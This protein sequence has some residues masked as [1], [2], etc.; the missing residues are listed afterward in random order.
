MDNQTVQQ[1]VKL[2]SNVGGRPKAID[3]NVVNKLV[4]AFQRGQ[5]DTKACE[6]ARISR[7]TFYAELKRNQEFF[8]KIQDAKNY[9]LIAAGDIVTDVLTDKDFKTY[10]PKT[11]VEVA[12]WVLEKKDPEE[13]GK[14]QNNGTG[15]NNNQQNNYYFLSDT[16]FKERITEVGIDQLQ[17]AEL[18]KA[19]ETP[20]LGS[21]ST[22]D[23]ATEIR[24]EQLQRSDSF[25]ESVS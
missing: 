4:A 6:Y 9:W 1:P 16:Q 25:T 17:P 10:G 7:P 24:E 2:P 18:I 8:Y 14:N 12:K 5:S 19:L 23:D 20:D 3:E 22:E 11:R 15:I 21:Q 13:F